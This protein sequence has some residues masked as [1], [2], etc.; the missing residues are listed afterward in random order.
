VLEGLWFFYGPNDSQ[1]YTSVDVNLDLP[2]IYNFGVYLN[3]DAYSFANYRLSPS[4]APLPAGLILDSI[5]GRLSGTPA[6]PGTYHL[7]FNVDVMA[8][9]QTAVYSSTVLDSSPVT[10]TR[11]CTSACRH[12]AEKRP[13]DTWMVAEVGRKTAKQVKAVTAAPTTAAFP[14]STAFRSS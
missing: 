4:S 2:P 5:T 3:R 1:V 13:R 7:H 8:E 11:A 14:G 9:G 12:R 6:F 10:D